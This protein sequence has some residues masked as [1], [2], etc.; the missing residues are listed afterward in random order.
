LCYYLQEQG[1]LKKFYRRFHADHSRD[2][3]GYRTLQEVLGR[4]DM[5][6]FQ[7]EW[8]AFVAK[9]TYS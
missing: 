6:A 3:S 4:R 1:L 7:R 5:D 8:E 9:L 2:P